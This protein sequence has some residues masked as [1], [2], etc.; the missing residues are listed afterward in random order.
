VM[1]FELRKT[2]V[3]PRIKYNDMRE[4]LN[5]E[6]KSS[7]S[8]W[9]TMVRKHKLD[10]VLAGRVYDRTTY[11][12]EKEATIYLVDSRTMN[13]KEI[14]ASYKSF[15]ERE[16][17]SFDVQANFYRAIYDEIVKPVADLLK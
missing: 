1:P 15:K 17:T 14:K 9:N 16:R 2:T 3:N 4:F 6:V 10:L 7:E 8:E 12:D 13:S 5:R 11:G